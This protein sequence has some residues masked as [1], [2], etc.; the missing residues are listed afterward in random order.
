MDRLAAVKH[1][2]WELD[3][4]WIVNLDNLG[5]Y[6]GIL[7]DRDPGI[8]VDRDHGILVDRDPCILVDR[9]P[10]ILVDR[11]PGILVDRDHG[12]LVD[13]D[14]G[15]LVDRDPGILVDRDPGILCRYGLYPGILFRWDQMRQTTCVLLSHGRILI[16]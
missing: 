14:P 11:D 16:Y 1:S 5:L 13:R 7:V 3:S 2:Q 12:I 6:P 4:S 9:D 10:G 8:L 15:I